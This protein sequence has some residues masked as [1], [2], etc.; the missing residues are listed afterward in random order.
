M[1][2]PDSSSTITGLSLEEVALR[3]NK[4][5]GNV[6]EDSTIKSYGQIVRGNCFTFFNC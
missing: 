4:G 1:K 5:L 2:P 6:K 3:K